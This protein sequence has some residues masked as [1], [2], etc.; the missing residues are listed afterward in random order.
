MGV[1]KDP[2]PTKECLV[3]HLMSGPG[4]YRL[5]VRGRGEGRTML[6]CVHQTLQKHRF[7][8]SLRQTCAGPAD[9]PHR[10]G[11]TEAQGG[12]V[13]QQAS[14]KRW[15]SADG[16]TLTPRPSSE[17]FCGSLK[18]EGGGSFPKEGSGSGGRRRM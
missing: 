18:P 4:S 15:W 14:G 12:K 5:Q 8:R 3:S 7:M 1:V 10:S 9:S 17:A 16:V 2:A 13:S 6:Q 11:E